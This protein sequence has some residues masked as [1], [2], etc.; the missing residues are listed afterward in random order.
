MGTYWLLNLVSARLSLLG[1]HFRCQHDTSRLTGRRFLPESHPLRQFVRDRLPA[2]MK[3]LA[4][5]AAPALRSDEEMLLDGMRSD[6]SP[7]AVDSSHHPS[8]ESGVKTTSCLWKALT[9]FEPR[10]L[11]HDG[12]HALTNLV[13]EF[14]CWSNADVVRK[15]KNYTE[16]HAEADRAWGRP[17]AVN[18]W[19][20]CVNV[21][22]VSLQVAATPLRTRTCTT[23]LCTLAC[24]PGKQR[25]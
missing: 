8:R 24:P 14:F 20:L 12:M 10:A 21:V 25:Q 2:P 22:R 3:F 17:W 1:R 6:M 18:R 23:P 13:K 15:R 9:L 4:A 11:F 7:H 16:Q 19:D 5:E